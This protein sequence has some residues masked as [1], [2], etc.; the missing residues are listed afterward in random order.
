ML[1]PQCHHRSWFIAATLAIA[2]QRVAIAGFVYVEGVDGDLSDDRF[3]PTLLQLGAGSNM[4]VGADGPSSVPDVPDLDY[5]TLV[6]AP[7]FQLE[8]LVLVDADVGGAFSFIGVESGP[9]ISTPWDDPDPAPLLGWM[10]Y[11]SAD[12]GHDVLPAIGQGNGAI[13]FRGPLP[14]GTYTLWLMELDGARPHDYS[15]EFVVTP[16]PAPA[17]VLALGFATL[18]RRRARID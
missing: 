17:G 9:I 15:F 12:E 18:R 3:H 14:T 6:V 2:A 13:G 10:H 1:P 16:I 5:V 4:L 11:G 7:G 8:R